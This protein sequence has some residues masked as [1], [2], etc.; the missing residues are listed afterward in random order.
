M[1]VCISVCIRHTCFP[2]KNEGRPHGVFVIFDKQSV[3]T[4]MPHVSGMSKS[5]GGL[6]DNYMG[7]LRD[8]KHMGKPKI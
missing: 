4:G 1:Y 5:Q 2:T 6:G 8:G 3:L 7:Q